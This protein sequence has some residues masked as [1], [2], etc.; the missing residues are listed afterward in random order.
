MYKRQ[1][2]YCLSPEDREYLTTVPD[3]K[4]EI[5]EE[6]LGYIQEM[7]DEKLDVESCH[8]KVM[9]HAMSIPVPGFLFNDANKH[10]TDLIYAGVDNGRLPLLFEALDSGICAANLV[11]ESL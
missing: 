8:V 3:H 6:T 5:A 10:E 9:G 1:A 4:Q 2:Y 7:L 11:N